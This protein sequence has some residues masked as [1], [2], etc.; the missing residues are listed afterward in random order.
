MNE[1]DWEAL[2]LQYLKQKGYTEAE[3]A[4]TKAVGGPK[5]P[6]DEMSLAHSLETTKGVVEQLVCGFAADGDPQLYV[7][8]FD[9]LASWVDNSLDI[10]RGELS[11]VL[12]PAFLHTYLNLVG[13]DAT[14][15]ATQLLHKHRRR[16]ADLPGPGAAARAQELQQLQGLVGRQQLQSHRLGKAKARAKA[17]VRMCVCCH[18]LLS[19]FLHTSPRVMPMAAIISQHVLFELTEGLPVVADDDARDGA[20]DEGELDATATNT[21]S[22]ELGLLKGCLEDL[23][24]EAKAK[25]AAPSAGAG[26]GG[27][28]E[29]GDG[30]AKPEVPP[31]PKRSKKAG[32]AAAARAERE[33]AEEK[34][35]RARPVRIDARPHVP[36][37]VEELSQAWLADMG[38]RAALSASRLP[39]CCF[40]TFVNS[41]QA[42]ICSTF[43]RDASR[44]AAGFADAS[45]RLYNVQ[46]LSRAR[47]AAAAGAGAH[48][49]MDIDADAPARTGAAVPTSAAAVEAPG[50]MHLLGH[51]APVYSLSFAHDER[52]LFSGGGDGCIR[53]WSPDMGSAL[54]SL[55]G[56]LLPVW[57]VAACPQGWLLASASA[58][59]T[60]RIWG[61]DSTRCL[62]VLA[63]HASDVDCVA[64]HPNCHYVATASADRTVRLWDVATGE[65]VRLMGGLRGATPTCLAV[66]PD[67]RQVAAG[68]D[69]GSVLVWD[70]GTARRVSVLSGHDG[71]VWSVAFSHGSGA[72][73]ASGGADETV[74][75]WGSD[76]PEA[77]ASESARARGPRAQQQLLA[78][79][80]SS[81]PGVYCPLGAYRTKSTPVLSLAF[82]A[83]NLLMSAG[84]FCLRGGA[85]A[86]AQ[87]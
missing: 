58:D 2:I 73:L 21:T 81:A 3:A 19:H 84:A 52:L 27:D 78:S 69:D 12:Y 44:V 61:T 71:P 70:L 5:G 1:D 49:T 6:R 17:T 38:A 4:L 26:A 63:G 9:R 36:P 85:L 40:F 67:G 60:A 83:R 53:L 76:V 86:A 7:D 13:R 35:R 23:W 82:S 64:W 15:A 57:D 45:I 47:H 74:R 32:A 66:S 8:A 54:A 55:R 28:G 37:V 62:R 39:S 79:C 48:D 25:A 43:N 51:R 56:H 50:V 33:A 41:R 16:M 31:P 59:R 75:L 14:A 11:R 65:C 68:A 10:Y 77:A 22:V 29:G 80:R 72:V 20:D 24:E 46:S 42:L 87:Q 18:D 30:E 34:K